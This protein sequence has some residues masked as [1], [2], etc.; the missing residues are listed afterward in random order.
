MSDLAGWL[1]GA[2]TPLL[3]QL[4]RAEYARYRDAWGLPP[5]RT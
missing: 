1:D 5:E 2:A 3:V 4:P